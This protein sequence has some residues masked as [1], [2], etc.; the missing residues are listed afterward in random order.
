MTSPQ[1]I[2]FVLNQ[3]SH[4]LELVDAAFADSARRSGEHLVCHPGCTQCCHGAFA[5]SPLD[6]LRLRT[7]MAQL[8]LNQPDLAA[9]IEQRA[10]AYI[11]TYAADFPGNITTGLLGSTESEQEAFDEFANDAACPALNP[12]SGLCDIYASRPMTCR[13]F[14]PPIRAA[15]QEPDDAEAFAICEL[16]FTHATPE[17]IAAAEIH[18]PLSTEEQVAQLIDAQNTNGED[19]PASETIIAY[20][21]VPAANL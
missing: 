2:A 4:L 20:C 17:E 6:A 19:E 12:Q 7:G 21:L 14:G 18:I 3:D 15:Q 1:Q 9:A 13:V 8:R 5:I 11:A 10:Q 16:C